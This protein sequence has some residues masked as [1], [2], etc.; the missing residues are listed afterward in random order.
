M[1]PLHH[2]VATFSVDSSANTT[3]PEFVNPTRLRSR[4]RVG[5]G[6]HVRISGRLT[7]PDGDP[8]SG[9]PISVF[10]SS[11]TSADHRAGVTRTD[12]HGRFGYRA[13]ASTSRLLRFVYAG[14]PLYRPA[15]GRVSLVVPARTTLAS[16]RRR[17]LNGQSAIFSGRLRTL[18]P[19]PTGKLLELQVVFRG[20]WQTFRTAPTDARGRWRLRYRFH[21][22]A[23]RQRY[24]FRARLPAEAGYPYEAGFSPTRVVVVRGR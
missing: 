12:S 23:G 8:I 22:T 1:R 3:R 15:E 20:R 2:V 9:A 5:L 11:T 21:A 16:S 19:P 18:P 14:T 4:V 7:N 6:S 17:L 24:R 10:S 13:L